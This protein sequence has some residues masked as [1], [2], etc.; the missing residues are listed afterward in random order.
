MSRRPY[1]LQAVSLSI[2]TTC[3]LCL[4]IPTT[5]R[6]CLSASLQ[7][8]DCVSQHPYNLQT[9]SLSVPT[10]CSLCLSASLQPADCVSQLPYNL[11][12][13]FLGV[14][15]TC[16][17]CLAQIKHVADWCKTK[18]MRMKTECNQMFMLIVWLNRE[19]FPCTTT[20]VLND[21]CDEVWFCRFSPDGLMLAT[22]SKD[23]TLMIW[24][25][26]KVGGR[27]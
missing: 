26:D 15:T 11:Q 19:M 24:E 9:V 6:L 4:S 23:G 20:Q 25:V 27:W 16:R 5:C 21:H 12:T 2:P 13:V 14:S 7:P 22:G 3:R 18:H 8:A 10:T 17:L 1:N